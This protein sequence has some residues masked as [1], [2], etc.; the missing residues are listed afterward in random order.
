MAE[1]PGDRVLTETTHAPHNAVKAESLSVFLGSRCLLANTELKIAERPRSGTSYGLVGCNGCGKSTLLRL[2]AQR[3]LPVPETWD[4]FLLG[5]HLSPGNDLPAIEEVLNACP[6]RSGLL[7]EAKR[8]TALLEGEPGP[9]PPLLGELSEAL[10]KVHAD[11]EEWQRAPSEVLHILRNLGFQESEA[12]DSCPAASTPLKQL[13]GGWRMKVELAKARRCA[14]VQHAALCTGS[15][16]FAELFL[17]GEALWLRPK[18]LLLDDF[19][20]REWLMEQIAEYPHTAV[21]PWLG[22]CSQG[23]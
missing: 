7:A 16:T 8:L 1:A 13:S 2:M 22:F 3:K 21:A 17:S 5:Q 11:L 15:T 20:A 18:L 10:R 19:R 14:N 6:K 23:L 4:V 9:G 12:S